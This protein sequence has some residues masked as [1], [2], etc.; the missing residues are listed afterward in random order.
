MS[1]GFNWVQSLRKVRCK[2]KSQ[3][4]WLSDLLL[5]ALFDFTAP[6]IT[7]SYDDPHVQIRSR[8]ALSLQKATRSWISTFYYSSLSSPF[9]GDTLLQ[10]LKSDHSKFW[11]QR[12]TSIV[13]LGNSSNLSRA[14]PV[15]L[16][17]SRFK[18]N[19][20]R[21]ILS[22]LVIISRTQKGRQLVTL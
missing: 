9:F 17:R 22:T 5:P 10:L 11:L 7:T 16:V 6:T 13:I 2:W 18:W 4:N 3:Q 20:R 12:K 21:S 19:T 1:G 15:T 14:T 8:I